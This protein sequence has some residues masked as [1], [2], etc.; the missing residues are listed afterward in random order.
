MDEFKK[1]TKE[2]YILRNGKECPYCGSTPEL[3]LGD[4]YFDYG[5]AIATVKCPHCGRSWEEIFT[6]TDARSE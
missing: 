5:K 2:E 6:L 3:K 4:S 1:L